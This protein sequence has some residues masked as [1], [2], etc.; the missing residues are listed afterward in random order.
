MSS[1]NPGGACAA[2]NHA[3]GVLLRMGFSVSALPLPAAVRNRGPSGSTA[4]GPA[5]ISA[6]WPISPCR[7]AADRKW[8]SAALAPCAGRFGGHGMI[9]HGVVAN[10]VTGTPSDWNACRT[11][12]NK[13]ATT[14]R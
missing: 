11:T 8:Y 5:I 3:V 6:L 4:S 13:G 12:P 1:L 2:L 7:E 14:C 9:L 10:A